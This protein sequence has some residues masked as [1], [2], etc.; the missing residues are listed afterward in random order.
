MYIFKNRIEEKI[1]YTENDLITT[2]S[3]L[4]FSK[5]K[6]ARIDNYSFLLYEKQNYLRQFN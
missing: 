3:F 5:R 2:K 1:E 6:F 4:T